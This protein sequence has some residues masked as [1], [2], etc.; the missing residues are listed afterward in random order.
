MS[1]I[2]SFAIIN[3]VI[4]DPKVLFWIAGSVT[5]AAVVNPNGIFSTFSIK[6]KPD[7]VMV[8]KV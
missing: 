1:F 8:L 6:S 7:L 3:V 5:D 4:P 2:S